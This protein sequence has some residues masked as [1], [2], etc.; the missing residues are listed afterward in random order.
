MAI[1][2]ARKIRESV[3]PGASAELDASSWTANAGGQS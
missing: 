3:G 2:E 1:E